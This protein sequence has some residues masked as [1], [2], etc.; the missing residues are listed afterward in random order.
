MLKHISNLAVIL[1]LSLPFLLISSSYAQQSTLA[2]NT[3]S[4]FS[5]ATQQAL[6][7]Q[8]KEMQAAIKSG[9][10]DRIVDALAPP[11]MRRATGLALGMKEDQLPIFDAQLV[12]VTRSTLG[13]ARYDDFSIDYAAIDY[14]TSSKGVSYAYVPA[15][16]TLGLMDKTFHNWGNYIALVKDGTW[17]V[18]SPSDAQTVQMLKVA[19]PELKDIPITPMKLE[20]R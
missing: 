11:A 20:E 5:G 8:L 4:Q 12:A 15:S 13:Q 7:L 6:T 3:N 1:A 14:K 17:L 2:A 18:L 10:A 9:D 16:M 19:F